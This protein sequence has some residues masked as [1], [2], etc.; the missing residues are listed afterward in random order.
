VVEDGETVIASVREGLDE[1]GTTLRVVNTDISGLVDAVS[2]IEFARLDDDMNA[3]LTAMEVTLNETDVALNAVRAM[4]G[5]TATTLQA[6]VVMLE[7]NAEMMELFANSSGIQT[8]APEIAV[9]AGS[10]AAT[11]RT[12]AEVVE[13]V[14]VN[15]TINALDDVPINAT[16]A[17]VR[18]LRETASPILSLLD[19][20]QTDLVTRVGAVQPYL[21][22]F[23]VRIDDVVS[24]SDVGS[25]GLSQLKTNVGILQMGLIAILGYLF[26]LH[27]AF[28]LMG[29]VLQKT[30]SDS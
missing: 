3:S 19:D 12:T 7:E 1:I 4:L 30:S 11:M 27:S 10:L 16:V 13:T 22:A 23:I 26:C 5:E 29:I 14:P 15:V 17:T 9:E 25:A 28:L 8:I 6:V 2:A 24:I 20:V 18:A 21:D